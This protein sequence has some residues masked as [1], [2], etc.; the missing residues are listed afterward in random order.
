MMIKLNNSSC[1][2][3]LW[4]TSFS[5]LL[6][7]CAEG[8]CGEKGCSFPCPLSWPSIEKSDG[9]EGFVMIGSVDGCSVLSESQFVE[10]CL[11]MD[12][13]QVLYVS[14]P[15]PLGSYC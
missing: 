6:N 7:P 13:T 8:V 4:I 12:T 2:H 15:S 14:L 5:S 3:P 11:G 10:A 1:V 9:T